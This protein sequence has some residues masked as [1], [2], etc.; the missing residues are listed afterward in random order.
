[1]TLPPLEV[2]VTWS[3]TYVTSSYNQQ[4]S[5]D[6][7]ASWGV[8]H[9]IIHICHIILQPTAFEWRCRLLRCVS[10][11]HTHMSHHLTINSFRMTLPPLEVCVT[12]S[13]T[14]VTSSY[15]Q[16][17]SNDAAASWGV[18]HMIIHICHIIL[19]STAFEW[20][21]R[22]LRVLCVCVCMCVCVCVCVC[23]LQD[24]VLQ[25]GSGRLKY[26]DIKCIDIS[27]RM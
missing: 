1:M 18:C 14:Y 4:L 24:G 25:V 9:M 12:W 23:V 8:C 7:A 20:R 26:P 13:Y 27:T 3:Y 17:L 2:C 5:N 21:Y 22:L 11:D 19:Q 15:N 10:H 6:A 16:Q